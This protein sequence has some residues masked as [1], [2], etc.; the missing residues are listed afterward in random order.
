MSQLSGNSCNIITLL[1]LGLDCDSINSTTPV[2]A[3]GI[4]A[5]YITG[6]TPPYNV[7]WNNGSQGT[8]ITNL[9]P[10]E[11]TATV[12]DYYGDFTATTTCTV[13]FDSFFIQE[14]ENCENE[15]NLIYYLDNGLP[16][17][18]VGK[19][20]KLTTQ[21]GCW[22]SNGKKIYTGQTYSNQFASS[23][24]G[25]FN[26]CEDCLPPPIPP[27]VYPQ[28]LCL[29]YRQLLQT[30]PNPTIINK[31]NF[32]LSENIN[33][34]PSW[35]SATPNFRMYYNNTTPRW[36]ISG[37]TAQ[38]SPYDGVPSLNNPAAPPIGTW[39][40]NGTN[41]KEITVQEGI[42]TIDPLSIA[43]QKTNPTCSNISDGSIV[44][45]A[46]GG[47]PPYQY[48]LN[49][50]TFQSSAIF[51]NLPSGNY[52]VYVK[53]S[54]NTTNSQTTTLQFQQGFVTY[55]LNLIDLGSTN[56]TEPDF[57]F[58]DNEKYTEATGDGPISKYVKTN[59]FRIYV[60]PSLPNNVTVSFKLL[61]NVPITGTTNNSFDYTLQ[62]NIV[63]IQTFNTST[64]TAPTFSPVITNVLPER[65][66]G[67]SGTTSAYT[68]T[69]D[70]TITGNGYI[71]GTITQKIRGILDFLSTNT[72]CIELEAKIID[73]VNL[74]SVITNGLFCGELIP[75]RIPLKYE[76]YKN[77]F[78]IESYL[79]YAE[80]V[81][82][83]SS[84][85]SGGPPAA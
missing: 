1:P 9:L 2:N 14:F 52:T 58:P 76:L 20:Y 39:I 6:G 36:E 44:V 22:L 77:G 54:L 4:V 49:N 30:N 64:A 12:V 68:Q 3:N 51:S 19:I 31:I 47:I 33:G 27:I 60:S 15:N 41:L 42:C 23:S 57:T 17:F 78:T 5:L 48:S 13:G 28:N 25:P 59:K 73:T 38:G 45:N 53:D 11:Y 79:K 24:S 62:E 84:K 69:Y 67:F 32:V 56:T 21:S 7:T 72:G 65:C 26:I 81:G 34:Y 63:S 66:N 75:S 35:S 80:A 10:G 40:L 82:L 29:T 16:S 71:E 18:I 43:I 74:N 70:A 46:T 55:N 37:W 50:V 83:T 61:I 85:G 8:L